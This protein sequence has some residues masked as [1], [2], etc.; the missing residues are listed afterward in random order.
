MY[1]KFGLGCVDKLNQ[2]G[3]DVDAVFNES[4]IKTDTSLKWFLI[5]L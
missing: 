5:K 3:H 1:L 4:F 2:I